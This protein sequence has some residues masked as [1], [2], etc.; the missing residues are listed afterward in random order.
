[1]TTS[2]S[3]SIRTQADLTSM[4]QALPSPQPGERPSVSLA[5]FD[6]GT[7]RPPVLF[8]VDGLPPQPEPADGEY[9]AQL[10]GQVQ[11]QTGAREIAAALVRGGA[12]RV[13]TGDRQWARVL[14]T[15]AGVTARWPLH[16]LTPHGA[17]V[18]APDDLLG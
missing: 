3:P 1:M 7:G 16:L 17:R 9:F 6:S 15:Q 11:E 14:S 12:D 5:F 10:V 4:W 8:C 18:L 2:P 13:D